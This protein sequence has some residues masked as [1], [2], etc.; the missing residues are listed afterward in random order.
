MVTLSSP[1]ELIKSLGGFSG[2]AEAEKLCFSVLSPKQ[3]TEK[4]KEL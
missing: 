3:V 4:A 2:D 1:G